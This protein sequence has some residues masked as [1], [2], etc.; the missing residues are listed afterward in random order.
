MERS[1]AN[2]DKNSKAD[3]S[4]ESASRIRP[5]GENDRK[6]ELDPLWGLVQGAE[7]RGVRLLARIGGPE[8]GHD[9]R[10]AEERG[11][12]VVAEDDEE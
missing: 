11:G 6:M 4:K 8:D 10:S 3:S 7:C 2:A 9:A 1:N 5:V 12:D